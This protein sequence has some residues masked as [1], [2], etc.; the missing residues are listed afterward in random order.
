MAGYQVPTRAQETI[1]CR[2]ENAPW[3]C[4]EYLGIN[5]EI[6]TIPISHLEAQ[7]SKVSEHA[8]RG[9]FAVQDIPAY[10]MLDI[11]L[12]VKSFHVPPSTWSVMEN[13]HDW[14]DENEKF[15]WV[16]DELSSMVTF[17]DGM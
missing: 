1:Y 7:K 4:D 13:L 8:G 6:V 9:L 15:H 11:D 2:S 17:T 10:S 3:E 5:P 14:A 16:E 12:A